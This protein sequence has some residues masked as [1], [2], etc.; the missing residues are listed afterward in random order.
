MTYLNLSSFILNDFLHDT[1]SHALLHRRKKLRTYISKS[2]APG[3]RGKKR[4]AAEEAKTSVSSNSS[5]TTFACCRPAMRL[6]R[7]S[8]M[9]NTPS[10]SNPPD[11]SNMSDTSHL[12]SASHTSST[13]LWLSIRCGHRRCSSPP[14]SSI[15]TPV[16]Q[17]PCGYR[18]WLPLPLREGLPSPSPGL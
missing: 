7:L 17:T 12:P 2:T 13:T 1:E 10:V 3:T 16:P 11:M 9:S 8:S 5:R 15:R 18:K 6:L 4:N 14:Q